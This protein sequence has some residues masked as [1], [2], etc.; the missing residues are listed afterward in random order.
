[1][2]RDKADDR[3]IARERIAR[4]LALAEQQALAGKLE[5][6]HR[7]AQLARRVGTRYVVRLDRA[8][9][10]KVCRACGAFLLPGRTARVRTTGGKV[11][12]TCLACGAARRHGYAREQRARRTH[13]RG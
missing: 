3:R 2:R 10:R 8:Q 1:V 12:T 11:T 9:R 4:L 13:G 7:Y 5:R 6:A